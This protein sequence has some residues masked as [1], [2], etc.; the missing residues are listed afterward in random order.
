MMLWT[1]IGAVA[2]L[3]FV[4]K[5]VGPALLGGRELPVRTRSVL[6]LLAPSLLAGFVVVE[7]AGARWAAVDGTALAGLA[8]AVALRL[9]RAPL[10]VALLGAVAVAALLRF[11]LG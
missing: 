3:S 2:V 7:V 11:T 8:A 9:A 6:A 1:A 4:L 10:P 5:G